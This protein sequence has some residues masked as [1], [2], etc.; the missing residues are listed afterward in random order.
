M[1]AITGLTTPEVD[2]Q[3]L[4]FQADPNFKPDK[5]TTHHSLKQ[6]DGWVRAHNSLRGE[7]AALKRA[8]EVVGDGPLEEWQVAAMKSYWAGHLLHVHGHHANEDAIFTPFLRTRFKYPEKLEADHTTLVA[9]T[10]RLA[11]TFATLA[12]GGTTAALRLIWVEYEAMMVPHLYEEEQVGLPLARAY[13]TPKE[14]GKKIQEIMAKADP[15]EM[16]S[17]FHHIGSKKDIQNFMRQEGIP[18]FVVSHLTLHAITCRH[19]S[20]AMMWTG[21]YE[22]YG[23]CLPVARLSALAR[24]G[25]MRP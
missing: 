18:Y 8:L 2:T 21:C 22:S 19:S 3:D 23:S 17:F 10:V 6:D 7:I 20:H 12:P 24:G 14:M 11:E 25:R 13:F 16:G 5:E 1:V 4:Q 15:L 9:L